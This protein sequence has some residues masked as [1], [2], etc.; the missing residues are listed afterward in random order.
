MALKKRKKKKTI[1][2]KK[3]TKKKVIRRAKTRKPV[4]KKARKVTKGKIKAK[5]KE[6]V[7]GIVT[8]YFPHVHAGVIK[9]KGPLALGEMIKIKGHTT[10]FTMCVTSMQI[11]RVTITNAKRGQEIGLLVP[12]R[13]RGNDKVYRV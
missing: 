7:L 2:R 12:T 9:L 4:A 3:T 5:P 13:V 1:S 6:K 11:D 10:D 8:H